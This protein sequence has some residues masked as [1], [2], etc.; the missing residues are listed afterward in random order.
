MTPTSR[1]RRRSGRWLMAGAVAALLAAAPSAASASTMKVTAPAQAVESAGVQIDVTATLDVASY[2]EAEVRPAGAPCAAT[3]AE[4]P[5][6]PLLDRSA[7]EPQFAASSLRAFDAAGQYIV[8][9]WARDTTQAASPVVASASAIIDVRIPKLSLSITAPS[10]VIVDELFTITTSAQA[11]VE[12]LAYAGLVPNLGKGCPANYSALQKTAGSV[13]VLAQT[14]VLVA[15][16]PLTSKEQFSLPTAGK[17]LACAYVHHGPITS[18]P[19][20]VAQTAFIAGKACVVPD[21][22]GRTL[23]QAKKLLKKGNC[24]LG[25]SKKATSKKVRRGRIIRTGKKPGTELAPNTAI[26]VVVSKGR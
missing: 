14:G 4:D 24:R 23:S 21:L 22:G 9:A 15:A 26:G 17:Y 25:K 20:A 13:A 11:E 5:G 3:A 7:I 18:A 19:Q 6:S 10:S 1:A 8:C 16:T 2:V 12:R